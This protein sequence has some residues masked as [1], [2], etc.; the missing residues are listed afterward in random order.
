MRV[1][2]LDPGIDRLGWAIITEN[3]ASYSLDKFGLITTD[4]NSDSAV[5]LA[6][7]A[8]DLAELLRQF[9]P[10]V[11]YIEK[12]FFSVNAKTAMTVSEVRGVIKSVVANQ[13]RP[14]KEIHPMQLKKMITGTGKAKKKDIQQAMKSLFNLQ[15]KFATDDVADAIAI[16][17]VGILEEL[18]HI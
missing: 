2:G 12:L 9:Q 10:Q 7:I 15:E 1:L 16:A 18:H 13:E 17:Y 6:E 3:A 8:T 14:V 5:R 4:K 11:V